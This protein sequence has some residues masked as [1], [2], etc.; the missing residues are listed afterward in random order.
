[1]TYV[2][3]VGAESAA[4]LGG[5]LAYSGTSQGATNAGSYAITP[6]GLTAGN[7]SL[8][9]VNGT[10]TVN[11]APIIPDPVNTIGLSGSRVYDGTVNVAANI[12]TLSGLVGGQN[13]SLTG[14]GTVAD[15]NV[16]NNKPV[17]LGSLALG[18]GS[19]GLASNYT[20][21][22]G[23]RSVTITP[24]PLT[25]QAD[26]QYKAFAST[27][28][29]LSYS[30]SGLVAGDSLAGS[31]SGGLMRTAGEATGVYGINQGSL[32]SVGGN[33]SLAFTPANLRIVPRV[34]SSSVA[35]D[36]SAVAGTE[37]SASAAVAG[38]LRQETR[39]RMVSQQQAQ[40][41]AIVLIDGGMRLP[42]GLAPY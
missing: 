34:Q 31:L 26:N 30:T 29:L 2:G 27:D 39:E 13:L 19:T 15:K 4:V 1:M 3:F 40:S 16:G 42:T 8:S 23:T 38:S 17:T 11:P 20:L 25:V 12:F 33:Y 41:L 24:A 10:L 32:T 5:T 6:G 37:T 35:V 28:P 7:Y 21:S 9:Y 18:N 22:G 36:A 14:V